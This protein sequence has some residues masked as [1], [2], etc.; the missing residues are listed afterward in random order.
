VISAIKS[1]VQSL[2]SPLVGEA[3]STEQYLVRTGEVHEI[4]DRVRKAGGLSL[5]N[6]DAV[7][8]VWLQDHDSLQDGAEEIKEMCKPVVSNVEGEDGDGE[9]FDGGWEELGMDSSQTLSPSELD[10]A[11]KVEALVENTTSPL[12]N[13]PHFQAGSSRHL[14]TSYHQCIHPNIWTTSHLTCIPSWPLVKTCERL[15][16][17]L[18]RILWKSKWMFCRLQT[19]RLKKQGN[20]LQPVSTK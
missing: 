4:I 8:K 15:F 14:M 6:R 9:A 20:G 12:T 16:S 19:S 2:L 17:C 10:R 1:L 11:E 7:Q 18:M 5:T 13:S 3:P